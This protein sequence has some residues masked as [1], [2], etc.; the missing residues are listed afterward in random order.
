MVC[1][2]LLVCFFFSISKR[3]KL[4]E[5]LFGY[6]RCCDLRHCYANAHTDVVNVRFFLCVVRDGDPSPL[7]S[8]FVK[9]LKPGGWL[10]WTEMDIRTLKVQAAAGVENT[11]HTQTLRDFAIAPTPDWPVEYVAP[12]LPTSLVLPK[13]EMI[14]YVF[15]YV[16]L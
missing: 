11:E 12:S 3:K 7:L 1:H 6:Q 8:L 5:R 9:M 2:P 15:V 14:G 16:A 10:Q 13:L 4:S